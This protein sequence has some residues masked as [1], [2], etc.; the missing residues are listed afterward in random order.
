LGQL[1]RNEVAIALLAKLSD[2]V[3]LGNSPE[4][5]QRN[6]NNPVLH[7]QRFMCG[8]RFTMADISIGYALLL[9]EHLGLE[10]AFPEAVRHYWARQEECEGFL[11]ACVAEVDAARE[12]GVNTIPS[13]LSL[14]PD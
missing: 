9:A 6:A 7:Q 12:Q 10:P 14:M 1:A 2:R 8:G 13:P 11:R 5:L 3:Y 4:S